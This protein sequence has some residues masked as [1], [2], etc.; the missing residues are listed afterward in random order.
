MELVEGVLPGPFNTKSAW[1]QWRSLGMLLQSQRGC[2]VGAVP[3]GVLETV[4][5]QQHSVYPATLGWNTLLKPFSP[6]GF[7]DLLDI[8]TIVWGTKG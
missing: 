3:I 2:E 5:A 6:E 8:Q 1:G 4:G 7:E